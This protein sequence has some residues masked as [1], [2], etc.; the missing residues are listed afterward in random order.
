M[1]FEHDLTDLLNKHSMEN[2]SNTPDFLLAAY[3]KGCLELWNKTVRERENWYGRYFERGYVP[4]NNTLR[5]G[6]KV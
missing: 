1:P 4:V 3:L 6:D 2:D 5:L